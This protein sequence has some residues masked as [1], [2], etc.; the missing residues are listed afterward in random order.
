MFENYWSIR[1][2]IHALQAVENTT[3]L[4]AELA[5][6]DEQ[7]FSASLALSFRDQ[8]RLL[9]RMTQY[10]KAADAAE[11]AVHHAER[12]ALSDPSFPLPKVLKFQANCLVNCKRWE[13]ALDATLEAV[14]RANESELYQPD[15]S[16][17][18]LDQADV[19]RLLYDIAANLHEQ[20][21]CSSGCLAAEECCNIVR[22]LA[23]AMPM[24]FASRL[25]NA[26]SLHH[27]L[28]SKIG[29]HDDALSVAKEEVELR[30]SILGQVLRNDKTDFN[31]EQCQASL[32]GAQL[33]AFSSLRALQ[34]CEEARYCI[35]EAEEIFGDL[36]RSHPQNRVYLHTWRGCVDDATECRRRCQA[37]AEPSVPYDRRHKLSQTMPLR[38]RTL[39]VPLSSPF[40]RNSDDS[41]LARHCEPIAELPT[42][43]ESRECLAPQ[44]CYT[45]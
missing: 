41:R 43:T 36:Q 23:R 31:R 13:E 7:S 37:P 10:D 28:L 15:G 19:A 22:V 32:G 38:P 35:E 12:A 6:R 11:H 4:Y 16:V 8:A 14:R 2:M 18:R 29:Q 9:T 26:L 20:D 44:L 39:P 33:S 42:L 27:K 17:D 1:D 30:R 5:R 3:L 21:N 25:G 24:E 45:L 34:R 40:S